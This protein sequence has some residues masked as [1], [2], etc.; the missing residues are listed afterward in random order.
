MFTPA[1]AGT[2]DRLR[3]VARRWSSSRK[4]PGVAI[5]VGADRPLPQ[6]IIEAPAVPGDELPDLAE[7]WAWAHAHVVEDGGPGRPCPTTSRDTPT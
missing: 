5:D 2:D 1:E 6:L 3:P 7:S 4:Q